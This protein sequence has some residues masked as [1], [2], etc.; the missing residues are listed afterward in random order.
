MTKIGLIRRLSDV[1]GLSQKDV[2][3]ILEAITD[4]SKGLIAMSLKK[5]ENVTIAGFGTFH[6]RERSARAARNPKTGGKVKVPKRRYPAF[7]AA[8]VF[9]EAFKK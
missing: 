1:T 5:G 6:V 7:K 4:S 2:R 3:V 8:K 9:K